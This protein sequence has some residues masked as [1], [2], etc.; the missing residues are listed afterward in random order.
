[1]RETTRVEGCPPGTLQACDPIAFTEL[2]PPGSG[3]PK[4]TDQWVC[5]GSDCAPEAR[6]DGRDPVSE[7]VF[8]RDGFAWYRMDTRFLQTFAFEPTTDLE[9]LRRRLDAI[10]VDAEPLATEISIALNGA[11]LALLSQDAAELTRARSRVALAWQRVQ[12]IMAHK[13]VPELSSA[14]SE[15]PR[16]LARL[17]AVL[18]GTLVPADPCAPRSPSAGQGTSGGRVAVP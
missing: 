17:D 1:L 13:A 5:L 7:L 12:A 2:G 11:H 18:G 3:T 10:P 15:L 4:R 8:P 14:P 9:A 16:M 6:Q